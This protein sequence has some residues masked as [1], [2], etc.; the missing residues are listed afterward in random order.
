M[1]NTRYPRMLIDINSDNQLDL[2]GFGEAGVYLALATGGGN[3]GRGVSGGWL[4]EQ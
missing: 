4:G 2:V 1:S 3:F